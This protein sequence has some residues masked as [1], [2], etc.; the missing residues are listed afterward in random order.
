MAK[1]ETPDVIPTEEAVVI[2]PGQSIQAGINAADPFDAALG[3]ATGTDT[4]AMAPYIE[5]EPPTMSS[6]ALS[7]EPE[8]DADEIQL[9]R[10]RL[11]QG[12]TQEVSEGTAKSGQ[13]LLT[14]E[15]PLDSVT[16]VPLMMGR[17]RVARDPQDTEGR[18]IICQSDDARVGV[19]TPGGNCATCPLKEF[20]QDPRTGRSVKP[21]C[22]MTYR[23][24]GW[25]VEHQVLVEL[26]FSKTATAAA[27]FINTFV[28][29]KRLGNFAIELKSK[30]Q[31]SNNRTFYV[32]VVKL[33]QVDAD[34]LATAR[35]AVTG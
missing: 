10:L 14:G 13:W 3:D 21:A 22:S 12:L 35:A 34:E 9:P 18:I 28:S 31:T 17:Y 30:A 2:E 15:E 7:M 26:H 1:T 16:V 5:P 33:S 6:S 23:Y 25:S 27:K 8:L 32:P 24:L 11:A 29:T 4:Q 19:G 20:S